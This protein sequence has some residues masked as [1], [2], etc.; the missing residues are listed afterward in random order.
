[1]SVRPGSL[2]LIGK[3]YCDELFDIERDI[4]DKSVAER[5]EIRKQKA[6]PI[7]DGFNAWLKS[8]K[9]YASSKSKLGVA[10]G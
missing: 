9:P 1:M 6:S 4:K 7:L 8:V 5:F 10:I 2:A 3:Q